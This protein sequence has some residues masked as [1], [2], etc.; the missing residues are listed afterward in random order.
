MDYGPFGWMEQYDPLFAKW[1]GSGEHF[2]FINQPNAALAN[3]QTLAVSCAPLLEKGDEDV[4][5]VV[6]AARDTIVEAVQETWRRKLGFAYPASSERADEL[7]RQLQPL[8]HVAEADWVTCWRQMAVVAGLPEGV[9]DEA[10][11]APL[12][13]WSKTPGAHSAWYTPL[14]NPKLRADWVAF[15]RTWRAAL[16]EEGD[17]KGAPTRMRA[18]NPKYVPREWMLVE[19]YE[20]ASKGD[21]SLVRELHQL[22]Q[23]PYGEGSEAAAER[24]YRTAPKVALSKGGTAFMS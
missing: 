7:W 15:L 12:D 14:T 2:A 11:M 6:L 4:R 17:R 13:A 5:E 10:L 1:T 19:A 23:D 8:M 9:D 16:E 24:Y 21:Y 3:F 18:E 22:L 20:K